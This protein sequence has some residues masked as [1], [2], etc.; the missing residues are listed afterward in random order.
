MHV[1]AVSCRRGSAYIFNEIFHQIK[2]LSCRKSMFVFVYSLC[3]WRKEAFL[4]FLFLS[5]SL[6][7]LSMLFCFC[8]AFSFLRCQP[9]PSHRLR[10][11]NWWPASH[12]TTPARRPN[13]DAVINKT[14]HSFIHVNVINP[15]FGGRSLV[16]FVCFESRT[17]VWEEER[18][19][20]N[21]FSA[22]TAFRWDSLHTLITTLRLIFYILAHYVHYRASKKTNYLAFTPIEFIQ[23]W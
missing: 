16:L 1:Q 8:F 5:L 2:S 14:I 23:W 17:N 11:G 4:G 7:K 21:N 10:G 9:G 19:I 22:P 12:Y 18:L 13:T 20:N 3:L 6:S 15:P